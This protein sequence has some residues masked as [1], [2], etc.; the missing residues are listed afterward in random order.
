MPLIA[1]ADFKTVLASETYNEAG[2]ELIWNFVTTAGVQSHTAITP[3]DTGGSYDWVNV[4]HGMYNIELPDSV[5]NTEGFGWFT[6]VATDALPWRG[7]VIGFRRAALND[8]LIDGST[9]STNLEDF[10][11]GTGYVG[12]TAKLTVDA[13]KLGGTTL[14][15]RDIG[16]SVLLSSGTGTG[17]LDFTSGVIK[18]NLAQILGTALTET[19]GLIAAAFKKFFNVATPTGTVNSL[20]DAV[21]DAAGGLPVTGTRLTAIPWNAAW[22]AEVQSEVNDELVLQNLDHLL[23]TAT[24]GVDM[25][26]EVTDG[27]VISR[28]ISNSDTSL[29]VPATSNLTT[30]GANV[31]AIDDYVDAEIA[32]LTT[33]LAKVPKSDSNV[34]WNA[35][36]LAS[37]NAEVD[38]ALNT[39]IPGSPTADSVNERIV[40][41][42][43]FGAPPSAA[44]VADA[45]WDE[46][47]TGHTSA[48]KAGEQLWTD[49][50]LILADTGELQTDWV[51]G[52]RLDLILDIIAADTTTDIPALI[53]DVPT[54]A[55]FE[56]RTLVAAD[57]V[58][59]GDTIAAVTSVTNGVTLANDAITAAKFDESTAFPLAAADS[60]ATYIA[61]APATGAQTL[62]TIAAAIAAIGTGT[63]AALNFAVS[64]DNAADAIK[65]IS[66]IGTQTGTYANTLADDGTTHQLASVE[67]P[68]GTWKIDWVYGFATGAGRAASKFVFRSNM[69]ATLDIVTVQAY[70]FA[71]PG[72]DT[73]TTITG[74]T[75]TLRDVPLLA[76]HTGTGADEGKVYIR[77]IFSETDAATL[78]IDEA[79][80]QAQQ[81]GSLIGY[82]DGAIWVADGGSAT[83]T[84]YVDGTADNPCTWA[85]AQTIATLIGLTRFRIRNGS[86][87]TLAAACASKSLIGN[88]WILA[89]EEQSISG[90]YIEGATV[91]GIGTG[92]SQPLFADCRIGAVTLCPAVFY[93]C[94]IGSASGTFTGGAKGSF[95][96]IDCYSLVGAGGTPTLTFAGLGATSYIQ[97]RRWT[98]GSSLT[99]DGDCACKIDSLG[100]GV[101][102]VTV[103]G[104]T[105]SIRGTAKGAALTTV[106]GSTTDIAGVFGPIAIAGTGGTVTISGVSG[107]VTDT[108][109]GT[110]LTQNQIN[111]ASV[112]TEV[113]TALNTAIP[114][115]PTA[116]SINERVA[117]MDTSVAIMRLL[118]ATG[119]VVDDNDPDPTA[120]AFET[121]L[122]EASN[123]HYNGA[124]LVF[125]SGALLDQSRKVA[126]YVG[127]TK[128]ITTSAFTEAPAGGDTFAILGRSE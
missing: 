127:A 90:S 108:S 91:T 116:D 118:I 99:L 54:V 126:G 26:T 87:V 30:L 6:G 7:P 111:Q 4:G 70:N 27:S 122:A 29:F 32:T 104:G 17:Q 119:T 18:A 57:Y 9:A 35:T 23:K 97:M 68:A 79:Y 34:T 31:T 63:G 15:A 61:R 102:T 95:E 66:K 73:R 107:V 89:L 28:I 71:S 20:P 121:N 37:I 16:L 11:D 114:G 117:T 109:S 105:L 39:A 49:V 98:A 42:D 88:N 120:T 115:S 52:G 56:A 55:E 25:T 124:F 125:T 50:D 43:A 38:G 19:G 76:S 45:V 8:L 14:T 84:P 47:S 51:Q 110:T 112:N 67:G 72:W 3:T 100:G 75:E 128:I 48:G 65:S 24:A 13:T 101:H 59:V 41:I 1:V 103:G 64:E 40:A 53:A 46:V 58:V 69:S 80:V 5:N 12:G 96:F 74:T 62:D 78:I 36:A 92:A 2:L 44:T 83:T 60:G 113:D 77:F 21:P 94:G 10:F 22:D 86:T 82:A 33:E 81:S 85:A 93:R 123:D 106:A